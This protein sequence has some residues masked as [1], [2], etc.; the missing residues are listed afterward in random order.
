MKNIAPIKI[1]EVMDINYLY[2]N[3]F[4]GTDPIHRISVLIT[5]LSWKKLGCL[6]ARQETKVNGI[7]IY[8]TTYSFIID[9]KN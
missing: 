8:K 6:E 7:K 1:Q 9:R 5:H 3:R 4:G 2:G